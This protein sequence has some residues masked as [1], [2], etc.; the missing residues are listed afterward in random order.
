MMQ[1]GVYFIVL[2]PPVGLGK[3]PDDP[4]DIQKCQIWNAKLTP[5]SKLKIQLL[6][7]SIVFLYA[8]SLVPII[9][10]IS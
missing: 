9:Q 3:S 2:I 7:K 6:K 5:Y 8:Y 10:I 4:G 1:Y